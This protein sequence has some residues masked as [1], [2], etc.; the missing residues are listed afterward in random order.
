MF[1]K[2]TRQQSFLRMALTGTSGSGKTYSA[3]LMAKG[4]GGKVAYIDTEHGS[5]SLYSDLMDFDVVNL[6][7][8][9][10]PERYI[11]IIDEAVKSGYEILI[12]DSMTHEWS[13]KGGVLE[14]VDNVSNTSNSKN[15]YFA[16][17]QVT[18]RH[19][20][21]VEKIL[22]SPIHII[23]TMRSKTD[24]VIEEKNGKSVPK[25][26]G[27]APV[28]REGL[29]YEF[30]AV[31]D[32]TQ[33]SNL[34]TSSKD[35]TR[36]FSGDP[37]LIS[38]DTGKSLMDWLDSG[39][40]VE[41]LNEARFNEFKSSIEDAPNTDALKECFGDAFRWARQIKNLQFEQSFTAIKDEAKDRL[42]DNEEDA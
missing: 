8:P 26:V 18:P 24:F 11:E 38:K 31:L 13:G 33:G 25:K 19:N 29:E 41:E 35:R 10:T 15:S 36:L 7:P 42:T 21:F 16:W 40:S 34:A 27:L 12:I 17:G 32:L 22:Q 14:I 23:A 20:A 28:Q 9:Y 6:E 4:M 5:A 39:V 2:A 1:Q 37:I 3:L 30:T